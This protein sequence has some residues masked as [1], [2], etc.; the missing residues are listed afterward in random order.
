VLLVVDLDR[1]RDV[2]DTL[3]RAHGDTVLKDVAARISAP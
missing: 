1:F 3:G 2:N